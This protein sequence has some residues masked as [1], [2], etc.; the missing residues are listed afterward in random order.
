MTLQRFLLGTAA[1]RASWVIGL[2]LVRPQPDQRL[3]W[4]PKLPQFALILGIFGGLGAALKLLLHLT[5][6]EPMTWWPVPF[7]ISVGLVFGFWMHLILAL[8]WNRRARSLADTNLTSPSSPPPRRWWQS[9]LVAPVY[10]FLFFLLTPYALWIALDNTAGAL[11]WQRAKADLASRREPLTFA[12][13]LGTRPPDDQ[14]FQAT[15]LFQ[16]LF[17]VSYTVT[18]NYTF[19][20]YN[21]PVGRFRVESLH[22]PPAIATPPAAGE[23]KPTRN[24][25]V[26]LLA[27]A[28]GI[29]ARPLRL[30]PSHLGGAP[31]PAQEIDAEMLKRYG[32]TTP[33]TPPAP[34]SKP[35]VFP[36]EL[37]A[38][39]GLV[40]T[41]PPTLDRTQ[42]LALDIPDPAGE[43]L[44]YLERFAPEMEELAA[45]TDRPFS[46]APNAWDPEGHLLLPHLSAAKSVSTLF[47][48]RAA[49]RL[50]KG[51]RDGAFADARIAFRLAQQSTGSPLLISLLVRLA[52]SSAA[53][54]IL[55]EG[56]IDHAWT[57]PQL[58][59]FDQWLE[60]ARMDDQAIEAFRG[61]RIMSLSLME[62][63]LRGRMQATALDGNTE[64]LASAEL[65]GS[66][67]S[68]LQPR[69][70]LHR[71]LV[72]ISR[73]NDHFIARLQSGDWTRFTAEGRGL[74]N[75][76]QTADLTP[77]RPSTL[78]AKQLAPA[79]YTAESKLARHEAIRRMARVAVAL[80]RHRLRHGAHPESLTALVPDFLSEI[81]LDPMTGTQFLRYQRLDDG[82]FNLWSV[83]LNGRDD[84][85]VMTDRQSNH[86]QTGD[87]VWPPAQP[88][89]AA[90]L[91]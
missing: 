70:F 27:L 80:E 49:A 61:E 50:A 26:D 72:S 41:N 1:S 85:G 83:G 22:L 90:R 76:M 4:F 24:S 16:P 36:P 2:P 10:T 71:S 39:Y 14:N 8:A 12:E 45:A 47:R 28:R 55:W 67:W 88:T 52:Q 58:V 20:H 18:N 65:P 48:T 32:L 86:Y 25:R 62:N 64:E 43:V 46:Q 42:A 13:L 7:L 84:G 57:E 34:T 51:D 40:T 69:G 33:P 9:W 79:L 89:Q 74:D 77:L 60:D 17:D 91:F 15:P 56:L 11:A 19:I 38:R 66:R 81:P 75:L 54:A 31:A 87:W 37:A 23:S 59:A 3:S 63:M 44:A 35:T 6:P 78:M 21:D 68:W 30:L 82:T 53:T 73:L 29:R 5:V